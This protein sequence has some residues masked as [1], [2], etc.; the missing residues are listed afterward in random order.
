G[1]GWVGGGAAGLG[2]VTLWIDRGHR[3]A[4]RQDGKLDAPAGEKGIAADKQR[5]E[6]LAHES[7]ECC[8]DL[9][10]AGSPEDLD[11]QPDVARRRFHVSR[12]GLRVGRMGRIDQHGNAGGSRHQLMHESQPL[13]HS[14]RLKK[15]IPVRLPPGRARLATR[16]S[17]TGSSPTLNT[18]GMVVVAALATNAEEGP[19]VAAIMAT[20]R[21][22]SSA[23]SAGNRSDWPSAQR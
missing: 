3:V 10:A 8:I 11:L 14:S 23:A 19:P 13:C 15:L 7:C 5:V 1:G 22:T 20:G 6:L 21:R 16:P 2:K 18:M 17:L 4:R 12:R 9:A